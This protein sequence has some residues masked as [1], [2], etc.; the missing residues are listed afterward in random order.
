MQLES[1]HQQ[2]TDMTHLQLSVLLV[3]LLF[4]VTICQNDGMIVCGITSG[5]LS[6]VK[7]LHI[8]FLAIEQ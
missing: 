2:S 6:S 5:F 4:A 3:M 1:L 8:F 7:I